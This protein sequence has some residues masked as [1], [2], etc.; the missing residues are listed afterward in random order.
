MISRKIEF[1]LILAILA[2]AAGLR[3]WGIG[4]G[5]PST[6][7]RPDEDRLITVGLRLSPDDLDPGYYLWPGLPFYLSRLLL[8]AAARLRPAVSRGSALGLYLG[9]PGFVHLLFRVV[10]LLAGLAAVYLLYRVGRRLFS[11][12]AG[13]LA[14]FFLALSFLHARDSRFAML[15]IPFTLLAVWFFLPAA[16]VLR[17]GRRMDYLAAGLL[18]GLAAAV[19]YY[20]AVLAVP[21]LA[22]HWSRLPSAG[23]RP[24]GRLFAALAAAAA[25]FFI[26]SPYTFLSAAAAFR[27]FRAEIL[28]GQFVAGFRLLPRIGTPRGWLHHPLFSLRWGMGL[29]LALA[30]LAGTAYCGWRAFRNGPAERLIFSFIAAFFLVLAFQRSCFIRYTTALIPFLCLAAAVLLDRLVPRRP[31]RPLLLAGAAV[32]LAL[33]PA[34]R[35][36]RLNRVLSR[37]DTRL[38]AG[39]W[40]EENIPPA[41]LLVFPQPLLWT[42]PE[43]HQFHPNRVVLPPGSGPEELAAVLELPFPG[44]KWVITGEHPLAYADLDPKIGEMLAA[45]GGPDREFSGLRDGG[46]GAVYDPFDAFF[47]PLAGFSG[48]GNPGPDIRIYLWK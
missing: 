20:G 24:P 25:V 33:E 3:A 23:K 48:V 35:I 15:D 34:A 44:R 46:R 29:P 19:K 30:A 38:L 18:L 26:A 9:D 36:V 37:P 4:Y 13:L 47:V 7:C 45:A 41:D 17:R 27:E 43:G 6:Y 39:R 5:L 12:P 42:R 31:G 28:T 22:A 1:Y 2:L 8:E 10:F 11:P 32:L 21:L 14:A 40:L 16:N